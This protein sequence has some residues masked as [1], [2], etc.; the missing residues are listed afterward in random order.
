VIPALA[1]FR[2]RAATHAAA[3]AA[4]AHARAERELLELQRARLTAGDRVGALLAQRE[5]LALARHE[6]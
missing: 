1:D 5:R 3:E 4:E 6:V 2:E